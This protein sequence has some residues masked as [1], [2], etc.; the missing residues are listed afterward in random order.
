MLRICTFSPV[1]ENRVLAVCY[2]KKSLSME[3]KNLFT[4]IVEPKWGKP[5]FTMRKK[6]K[7]EYEALKLAKKYQ[8]LSGS[9]NDYSN[10]RYEGHIL[11]TKE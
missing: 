7:N 5:T 10:F 9:L 11:K 1:A 4:C 6:V 3:N 2:G 8:R